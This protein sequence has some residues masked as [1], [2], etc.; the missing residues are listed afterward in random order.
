MIN[1]NISNNKKKRTDP[2]ISGTFLRVG[3]RPIWESVVVEETG[4]RVMQI[5]FQDAIAGASSTSVTQECAMS[6]FEF[7]CR[8]HAPVV[9]MRRT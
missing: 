3:L 8:S 1:F 9:S 2:P 5:V 4:Q 6:R 7:A